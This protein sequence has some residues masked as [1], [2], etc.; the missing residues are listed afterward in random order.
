MQAYI[1]VN[2]KSIKQIGKNEIALGQQ[3]MQ[4]AAE[5]GNVADTVKYLAEI[6]E[7]ATRAGQVVQS[8]SMLKKMGGILSRTIC[9]AFIIS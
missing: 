1:N 9:S 7:A 8:F 3:L 6:T 4:H 2:N 5:N